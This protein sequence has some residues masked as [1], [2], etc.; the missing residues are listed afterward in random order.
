[1]RVSVKLF[2]QL[3]Q[4]AGRSELVLELPAGA[5]AADAA[6]AAARQLPGLSVT[7]AMVAVNARYAKPGSRLADGDIVALLPPVSGG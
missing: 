2:A 4:A 5:T 3:K 7:G 6:A 1:M